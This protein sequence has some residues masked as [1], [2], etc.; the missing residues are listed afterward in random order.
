MFD[1]QGLI[2]SIGVKKGDCID[3][4]SDM[5]YLMLLARADREKFSG[6]EFIVA[7]QEAVGEEG[8]LLLRM[9]NWD[10]CKGVP[11]DVKNTKSKVGALANY[12]LDMPGFKRSKHAIYSWMVWGK[13]RDEIC[14]LDDDNAFGEGSV[15]A[16]QYNHESYLIRFGD[17]EYD[18]RTYFHYVEN[19]VSV[20]YRYAKNFVGDYIEADGCVHKAIYSMLVH[21]MSDTRGSHPRNMNDMFINEGAMESAVYKDMIVEKDHIRAQCDI[22]ERDLREFFP[23]HTYEEGYPSVFTL[24]LVDE[25][26]ESAQSVITDVD[27][28]GSHRLLTDGLISG[29]DVELIANQLE[30]DF[31]ISITRED[32]KKEYFDNV[33]AMANLCGWRMYDKEK[34]R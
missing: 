33:N 17:T 26:A 1:Y 13:Y 21:D 12:A 25:V 3:I 7:L 19:K 30:K 5:R 29:N 10:F 14:E 31:S 28:R 8:T 18:G 32:R 27:L 11:F 20:P 23:G 22:M 6:P 4:I 34:G 9:F 24:N 16:W 15:F 2:N